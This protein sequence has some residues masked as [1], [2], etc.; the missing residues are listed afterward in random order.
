[1]NAARFVVEAGDKSALFCL[2]ENPSFVAVGRRG[3]DQQPGDRN[4][5]NQLTQ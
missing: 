5:D 4:T 2:D 1:L 3:N